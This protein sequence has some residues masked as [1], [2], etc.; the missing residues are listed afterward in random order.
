VGRACIPL[1][2]RSRWATPRLSKATRLLIGPVLY[3]ELATWGNGVTKGEFGECSTSE[4]T[5]ECCRNS[6]LQGEGRQNPN[7]APGLALLVGTRTSL[8]VAFSLLSI[9]L[10]RIL[11]LVVSPGA[12]SR[13]RASRSWCFVTRCVLSNASSTPG[14]ATV[15]PIERSSRHSADCCLASGGAPS[16]SPRTR[17]CGGTGTRPNR[18]G[19]G[20]GSSVA[21]V[22]RR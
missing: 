7:C 6:L 19:A 5:A 15:L 21:P 17:C 16:W 20:G 2:L 9:G 4:L 10:C 11:G 14:F 8:S 13:T 1:G 12:R 3:S 18:S 22:G